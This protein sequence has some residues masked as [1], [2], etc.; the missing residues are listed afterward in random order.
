M[1]LRS[2]PASR[3]SEKREFN[4]ANMYHTLGTRYAWKGKVLGG[5][6]GPAT[7]EGLDWLRKKHEKGC[8]ILIMCMEADY[9]NRGCSAM[10]KQSRG[11]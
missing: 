1:D 6:P 3:W 5:K 2:I 8:T 7:E 9:T 10:G 11:G 4:K